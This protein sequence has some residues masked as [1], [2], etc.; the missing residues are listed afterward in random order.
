MLFKP[1]KNK[2][3]SPRT[4]EQLAREINHLKNVIANMPDAYR[5]IIKPKNIFMMSVIRGMG[6]SLGVL[7]AIAILVP[8][9]IS[10]LKSIEWVPLIGDFVSSVADRMQEAR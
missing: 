1:A 6:Y 7:L 2:Q 10:L 8:I 5:N 3:N 9:V 4:D